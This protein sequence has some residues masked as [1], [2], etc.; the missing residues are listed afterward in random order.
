MDPFKNSVQFSPIKLQCNS[1]FLI[2]LDLMFFSAAVS[3]QDLLQCCNELCKRAEEHLPKLFLNPQNLPLEV[4]LGKQFIFSE[5]STCVCSTRRWRRRS[6]RR[7][8]PFSFT[9]RQETRLVRKKM[10]SLHTF[11]KGRFFINAYSFNQKRKR[12][13]ESLALHEAIPGHHTQHSFAVLNSSLPK[14]R[15][16]SDHTAY[17]EGWALYAESLGEEMGFYNNPMSKLAKL[18]S[19]MFRACRLVVDTGLHAF[20]WPRY[21]SPDLWN[22]YWVVSCRQKAIEYLRNHTGFSEHEATVE[23][24][25]YIVCPG[26]ACAYKIGELKFKQLRDLAKTELDDLFDIKELHS[27]FLSHGALPLDILEGV[28]LDYIQKKKQKYKWYWGRWNCKYSVL[29]KN[30]FGP[31]TVFWVYFRNAFVTF[32]IEIHLWLDLLDQCGFPREFLHLEI[33]LSVHFEQ[34]TRQARTCIEDVVS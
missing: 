10:L 8:L 2:L 21:H 4:Q 30:R 11:C 7:I 23:V 16:H 32:A 27:E 3:K 17:V 5:H 26:Q 20:N 29:C 33:A 19:E 22:V 12:D 13:M 24:D 34:T 1:W 9:W 6:H 18:V 15:R 25:R 14:F 31:E 28:V